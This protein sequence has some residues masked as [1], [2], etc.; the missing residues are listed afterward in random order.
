MFFE[1]KKSK[2]GGGETK[3]GKKKKGGVQVAIWRVVG[4]RV[5]NTLQARFLFCCM[6]A[7]VLYCIVLYCI[8]LYCIV[9]YC[10]VLYST[11]LYCTILYSVRP[12]DIVYFAHCYP[13]SYSDLQQDLRYLTTHPTRSKVC[14]LTSLCQTM[15]SE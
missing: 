2:I 4:L 14:R 8:Q 11:V 1:K 9:L 3:R 10:I 12:G 13:Y 5:L 6:H 15:V 7:P